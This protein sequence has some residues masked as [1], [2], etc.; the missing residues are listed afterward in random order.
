MAEQNELGMADIIVGQATATP[1]AQASR[2]RTQGIMS[3]QN[4][5]TSQEAESDSM[6]IMGYV[7][8]M[9]DTIR[10]TRTP[11][12]LP[13][14]A[15]PTMDSLLYD[16]GSTTTGEETY[17]PAERPPEDIIKPR[18]RGDSGKLS[19]EEKATKLQRDANDPDFKDTAKAL[20]KKYNIPVS[21]L[22]GVIDGENRNW[23]WTV[24]NDLGYR[25]LV[26]IG[27][28]PA[29]EAGIDYYS[30][31]KKKPSEQLKEYDKY[32]SRWDYDG[33]VP[34]AVM[35]AAPGKAKSL[36][37]KSD[38]TV[39]YAVNSEE[40]AANPGWRKGKNGPVTLGSLR[41]YYR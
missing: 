37:G 16:E 17:G 4:K 41:D 40:W 24:T 21:E 23:D 38:N 10:G 3:Q 15:P 32:L 31:D 1:T 18:K 35:Q 22:Y 14:T 5:R 36:K 39:I 26:Q 30:L 9:L 7:S 29:A 34:L 28:T 33:S 25:G 20:A 12:T 8:A 2:S 11:A 6:D 13:D 19:F 27:K